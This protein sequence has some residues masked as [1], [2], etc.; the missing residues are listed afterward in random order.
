MVTIPAPHHSDT[1][2]QWDTT[3]DRLRLQYQLLAEAFGLDLEPSF[4]ASPFWQSGVTAAQTI[5]QLE[6]EKPRETQVILV[7]NASRAKH[8]STGES[9]GS[10]CLWAQ[11]EIEGVVHHIVGVDDDVFA[12]LA[13]SGRLKSGTAIRRIHGINYTLPSWEII[14]IDDLSKGTQFRSK[15]HFPVAQCILQKLLQDWGITEDST[16]SIFQ[17]GEDFLGSEQ[18]LTPFIRQ[19]VADILGIKPEEVTS[20]SINTLIREVG[21]KIDAIIAQGGDLANYRVDVSPWFDGIQKV[22]LLGEL[23]NFRAK[24]GFVPPWVASQEETLVDTDVLQKYESARSS[25]SSYQLLVVDRDK[26]GNVICAPANGIT[27]I[28]EFIQQ[29]GGFSL[30]DGE[31]YEIVADG[32]VLCSVHLTKTISCKTGENCLWES[33]SR[34]PSGEKLFDINKSIWPDGGILEA[35]QHLP[36]GTVLTVQKK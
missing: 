14:T 3:V 15:E 28:E 7:N 33:S 18:E 6:T 17:Y 29:N 31:N 22:Q 13:H 23:H 27:T 2:Q 1:I 32:Q 9:K 19:S 21:A 25:L 10:D 5:A 4:L 36:V 11:V 35:V 20:E 26:Y 12:F 8:V 16:D 30:E 24:F 34:W